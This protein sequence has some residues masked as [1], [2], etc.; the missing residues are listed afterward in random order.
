MAFLSL[1]E[2]ISV[3]VMPNVVFDL[4]TNNFFNLKFILLYIRSKG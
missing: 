3:F 1:F 4:C 2:S